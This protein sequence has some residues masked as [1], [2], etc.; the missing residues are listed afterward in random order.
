[1]RLAPAGRSSQSFRGDIHFSRLA[2]M[3]LSLLLLTSFGIDNF[4]KEKEKEGYLEL[5]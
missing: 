4:S 3:R 2:K 5:G 1:M